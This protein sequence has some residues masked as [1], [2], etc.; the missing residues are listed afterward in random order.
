MKKYFEILVLVLYLVF[1]FY[2]GFYFS[3]FGSNLHPGG[4]VPPPPGAG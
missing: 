1:F 4:G 2:F 3:V